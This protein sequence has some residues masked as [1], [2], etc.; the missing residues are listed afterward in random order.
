VAAVVRTVTADAVSDEKRGAVFPVTL[1]LERSHIDVDGKAVR[2]GPGMNL[3]AEVKTGKRR[4]I[5]YLLSPVQRAANE[6]LRER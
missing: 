2:L 3:T 4:I 6:S 1:V 5:E